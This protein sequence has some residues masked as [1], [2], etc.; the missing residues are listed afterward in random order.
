MPGSTVPL[1]WSGRFENFGGP[2][3]SGDT[4]HW[5]GL[6]RRVVGRANSRPYV[7]HRRQSPPSLLIS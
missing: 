3:A 5:V 1:S 6:R 2:L 7:R 4:D